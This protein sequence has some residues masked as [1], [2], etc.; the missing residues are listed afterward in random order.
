M[1][2]FVGTRYSVSLQYCPLCVWCRLSVV[3]TYTCQSDIRA[4]A[5][6]SRF[7][8][9]DSSWAFSDILESGNQE[10]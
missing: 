1:R 6:D 8:G 4:K 2:V 10:E 3:D 9:N 5:Q 7:R